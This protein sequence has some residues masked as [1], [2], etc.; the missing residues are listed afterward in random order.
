M[1]LSVA[2]VQLV[3][4]ILSLKSNQPVRLEV[5]MALQKPM[6]SPRGQS[7]EKHSSRRTL[8]WAVIGGLGEPVR[9]AQ[10]KQPGVWCQTGGALSPRSATLLS[11]RPWKRYLTSLIFCALLQTVRSVIATL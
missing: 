7:E 9:E 10:R 5:H 8:W 6:C 11:V 4:S 1:P 3:F 2:S